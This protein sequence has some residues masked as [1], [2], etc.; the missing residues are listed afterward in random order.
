MPRTHDAHWVGF[1]ATGEEKAVLD[2]Y[3]KEMQQSKTQVLRSLI[4]T[5]S[6]P[7]GERNH[8]LLRV[9]LGA[10]HAAIVDDYCHAHQMLP[11]DVVRYAVE[12]L[13]RTEVMRLSGGDAKTFI[14]MI[15]NPPEPSEQLKSKASQKPFA[16]TKESEIKPWLESVMA[17]ADKE[18]ELAE[19]LRTNAAQL[20]SI[21]TQMLAAAEC[22]ETR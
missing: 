15:N 3:C 18:I 19:Q 16:I 7:A 4:N 9:A 14:D 12:L 13:G 22:F 2:N 1:Q 5:L 21:A 6:Y 17:Q 8:W 10:S 11:N 20:Q